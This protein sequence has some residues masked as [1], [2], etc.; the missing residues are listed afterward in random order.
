M[1]TRV[2]L[3][4][5][6][7]YFKSAPGWVW[8]NVVPL[9]K[10]IATAGWTAY[11]V[12]SFFQ[13]LL[14]TPE[15]ENVLDNPIAAGFVTTAVLV[16]FSVNVMTK[17]F[18]LKRNHTNK[19]KK[20]IH[21]GKN[22]FKWGIYLLLLTNSTIIYPAY[23]MASGLLSAEGWW[24]I[25][26]TKA[27][28][29]TILKLIIFNILGGIIAFPAVK[30]SLTSN[31]NLIMYEYLPDI[32]DGTALKEYRKA[33]VFLSFASL[34][35][36]WPL[37]FAS[38]ISTAASLNQNL[39]RHIW[40]QL[41][42]G[43]S[44]TAAYS[45]L[46]TTAVTLNNAVVTPVSLTKMLDLFLKKE[47]LPQKDYKTIVPECQNF[48]LPIMT[49]CGLDGLN[50]SL[51]IVS[52]VAQANWTPFPKCNMAIGA[53]GAF[54]IFMCVSGTDVQ[55]V[56]VERDARYHERVPPLSNPPLLTTPLL[57]EPM[58]ASKENTQEAKL[59]TTPTP[60]V[61]PNLPTQPTQNPALSKEVERISAK[62]TS[63]QRLLDNPIESASDT[64]RLPRVYNAQDRV[65]LYA[66][67]PVAPK[68]PI[69]PEEVD[70]QPRSRWCPNLSCTI[71]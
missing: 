64:S 8:R 6:G 18:N 20:E 40:N 65:T 32:L 13:W 30:S 39:L 29:D 53:A 59:I 54:V 12:K 5:C 68:T 47:S 43:D 62:T 19:P 57:P 26:S 42:F 31:R 55:Y 33:A 2:I 46:C 34:G 71:S 61:T 3:N 35:L 67:P 24:G 27:V 9:L 21:L 52:T 48:Q 70:S 56:L 41:R 1:Q 23:C 58:D 60:S 28:D 14:Q 16:T 69:A 7:A 45:Y 44:T 22:P 15:N 51:G 66:Q 49:L 10:P 37:T 4:K 17:Y 11:P 36:G 50:I 38:N 25:F 63:T